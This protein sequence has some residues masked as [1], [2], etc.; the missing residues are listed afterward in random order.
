MLK[1]ILYIFIAL[2]LFTACDNEVDLNADFE[3]TTV[4]Y[5]FLNTTQD[6]QFIR[7][8]KAF[9]EDG[10][11]AIQLAK[12]SD[13]LY[14]ESLD[15]SMI[16]GSTGDTINLSSIE[17]PKVEGVFANDRNPVYFT[18]DSIKSETRYD[19]II[20][21]ADG[22]ITTASTVTLDET[23]LIRPRPRPGGGGLVSISLVRRT[24]SGLV[25]NDY[26]FEFRLTPLIS[27]VE[28]NLYFTY[29]EEFVPNDPGSR[30]PRTIFIPVGG[31]R[32][33][34][35]DEFNGEL[36]LSSEFF[37]TTIA[38]NTP[39]NSNRKVIPTDNIQLEI[40]AVDPVFGQYTSVYG[41][42]DGLAQVRPEFTNV[43]NG[44]G[45]FT[46]RSTYYDRTF[47]NDDSKSELIN[48]SITGGLN[49][50]FQ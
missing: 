31:L 21:Q 24:S 22:K 46:S 40:I 9:L 41:P 29:E 20:A 48:G 10:A 27:E 38:N 28:L 36:T 8:N 5:G 32:N 19:L 35:L 13:R 3:D 14:Y 44:I 49:F 30:V 34:N 39:N 47:L 23:G 4:V 42:L 16:D 15:V 50:D 12:E 1:N 6:T 33:T 25:L 7:V 43:S 37:F 17:K 26:V 45:L 18:T 2:L 11:N